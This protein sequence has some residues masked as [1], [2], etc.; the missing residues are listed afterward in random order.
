MADTQTQE[1]NEPKKRK[2][3]KRPERIRVKFLRGWGRYF[4][5]D[6]AWLPEPKVEEII[7]QVPMHG[8]IAELCPDLD[9]KGRRS[10]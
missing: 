8:P 5:G 6:I 10:K 3:P 9:I 7:Q 4:P 1:Q 2:S